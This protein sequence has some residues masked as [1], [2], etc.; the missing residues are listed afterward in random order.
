MQAAVHSDVGQ[1]EADD[2]VV[3]GDRLVRDGIEDPSSD[4]LVASLAYG[5]VGDLVATHP[6][7]VL[8]RAAR[9]EPDE[10]HLEAI[11]VGCTWPVTTERVRVDGHGHERFDRLPDGV[12]DFRVEARMM[13][14]TSTRSLVGVTAPRFSR[15]HHNDRWMVLSLRTPCSEAYF[16]IRRPLSAVVIPSRRLDDGSREL[17]ATVG[18][19]QSPATSEARRASLVNGPR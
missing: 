6:L 14:G 10:H 19:G 16:P 1:V 4:P 7:C 8:P 18:S 13:V 11:P 15:G 12:F 17:S 3:S 2:P 9:H 5:R